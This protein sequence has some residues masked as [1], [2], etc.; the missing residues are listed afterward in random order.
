MI[1]TYASFYADPLNATPAQR[2][3]TQGLINLPDSGATIHAAAIDTA[4]PSAS[5]SF[6]W[7]VLYPREGQTATPADPSAAST[8]LE[9][10]A[11]VWGD[12]RLFCVAT[13]TTT[14][15]QSETD[16]R[17]APESAFLTYRIES[18]RRALT[19]PAI[20]SRA[21]RGAYDTLALTLEELE[22]GA[23]LESAT[24]NAGGELLLTL[25]DGSTLNA[26]QVRGADGADGA[27]GAQGVG[28]SGAS[29]DSNDHLIF[30]LTDNSTLD[31]GAL[32]TTGA[33]LDTRRHVFTAGPLYHLLENG[34]VSTPLN[35]TKAVYIAGPW[36]PSQKITLEEITL[37]ALDGGAAGAQATFELVEV[38]PAT[39]NG[40]LAPSG[41]TLASLTL[42]QTNSTGSSVTLTQ[43]LSGAVLQ[44]QMIAL[45]MYTP[46]S[47]LNGL[48]V[49]LTGLDES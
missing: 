7:A 14:G 25:T 6:A 19:L 18:E 9:N 26:G 16:P 38:D 8:T 10:I 17:L 12:V 34:S 49:T 29:I 23:S 42:T 45:V 5:F 33:G 30:T 36:R 20:G 46:D 40:S 3:I 31:A 11:A 2:A 47:P 1:I 13:N 35:P 21:W 15:E 48:S 27:D 41:S 4:D 39:F 24:I 37:S 28:V 32:P 22:T 44:G 43:T